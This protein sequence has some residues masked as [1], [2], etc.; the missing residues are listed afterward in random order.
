MLP[1]SRVL[2]RPEPGARRDR[3]KAIQLLEKE[4]MDRAATA[5]EHILTSALQQ[6]PGPKSWSKPGDPAVFA[7]RRKVRRQY[8]ALAGAG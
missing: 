1:A 4:G 2:I 5:H 8:A 7:A 3:S 6:G